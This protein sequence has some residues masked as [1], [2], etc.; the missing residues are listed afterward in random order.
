[1]A[2]F[3]YIRD[4][5]VIND[6]LRARIATHN[7]SVGSTIRLV[8]QHV[9]HEPGFVWHTP[10]FHV[11]IVA[12][13]YD[14][15][16][17]AIDVSAESGGAGAAGATGAPGR[18]G[19]T[20]SNSTPGQP[21]G[22]GGPGQNG[23]AATSIRITCE[24]LR[25]PELRLFA[26]GGAGGS[27]GEG[28][29]GGEGGHG[30][31][32]HDDVIEGQRGGDGGSGG[33]GGPGGAGGLLLLTR[34]SALLFAAPILQVSGGPGGP[35]G[36]GG[37]RG[38]KGAF[39]EDDTSKRGATGAAGPSGTAGQATLST[40]T[41]DAYFAAVLAELGPGAQQWAAYR[42]AVGEYHYRAANPDVPSR[43]GFLLRAM[44][45]FDAVL[46]LDPANARAAQLQKQILLDQ[47]I[48]GLSNKLDLI[49]AF[50]HFITKFQGFGA[51]VFGEFHAGVNLMLQANNL[52][53][54]RD[55]LLL[56]RQQAEGA[57]ADN[58]EEVRA[59]VSALKEASD[60]VRDAQARVAGANREIEA[61]LGEMNNQSFS[62]G[63]LVGIVAEI[64][65]AVLSV[66][67][68]VPTG[69]ASL[70]AL[71]P[72]V[73][74]L[75]ESL[76]ENAG[77]ML[78]ALF[79]PDG[80]DLQ[81]VIDAYQRVNRNADD[82]FRNAEAGAVTFVNFVSLVH[83]LAAGTTPDNSRSIALVQRGVE[84]VHALLL[85]EHR[86]AQAG[87]T[88]ATTQAK[89]QRANELLAST[90]RLIGALSAEAHVLREA[91]LSAVR[92]AQLHVDPVLGFAFRAQRSAEIYTLKPEAKHL[93]LDAGY[94]HPDMER[95]Y[96]ELHLDAPEL[97]RGYSES[98]GRLLQP[99][100]MQADYLEYFD[101]SQLDDDSLR[102]SFT[103]AA[104]L[105]DFV[106]THDFQFPILLGDLPAKHADAKIQ[107]VF[108]SFVGARSPS[109]VISCEVRHGARY[110]QQRPD[111]SVAVQLLQPRTDT[112]LA[113]TTRLEPANVT[114]ESAPP[115]TAPQSLAFWGR[116]VAGLWGVEIPPGALEQDRPDLTAL[117]EIQV[118]VGYQFLRVGQ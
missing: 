42:L 28:G 80:P 16:G 68:A 89:L 113:R 67:A 29:T 37:S 22:P 87:H 93:S 83:R 61:A 46:R 27:G 62:I 26:N 48:L 90:Q 91:G 25:A 50:D 13:E 24:L 118:W 75:A 4:E 112:Q 10:G 74:A 108:V 20:G 64:G 21:G 107:G 71:V 110:E 76:S 92:N 7:L 114:F 11:V 95:D 65:G 109:G 6:A 78:D 96:A 59:A 33:S 97:I 73:M 116:G 85:A 2:D 17:G 56:Q 98:W 82:V 8:A 5:I 106:E 23:K 39:S 70:V 49:P 18:P 32:Q 86:T 115:L 35:G 45:E 38:K 57:V 88:V 19:G 77:P 9:T 15:N 12:G 43:D 51:L 54:M 101:N 41:T 52:D 40:V 34:V 117:S 99:I 102:L 103:D 30:R 60:D 55:Q 94:V 66:A 69:G 63:G 104:L 72:D 81:G 1:M 36:S 58:E 44:R 31:K 3:L 53:A 105:R 79:T 111:G 14:N 47:N 100:D 84:L